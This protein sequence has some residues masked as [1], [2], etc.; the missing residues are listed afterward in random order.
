M[1]LLALSQRLGKATL[2]VA[3]GLLASFDRHIEGAQVMFEF[4]INGT[5]CSRKDNF[6][7][8]LCPRNFVDF[9]DVLL[10]RLG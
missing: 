3:L 5:F 9:S 2:S 10:E 6:L 1:N 7:D 8:L 4:Q